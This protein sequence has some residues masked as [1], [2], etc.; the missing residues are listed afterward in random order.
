MYHW[1]VPCSVILLGPP[2]PHLVAQKDALKP[3]KGLITAYLRKYILFVSSSY[4]ESKVQS[5]EY[6]Q[7]KIKNY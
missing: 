1:H 3:T 5:I 4:S 2:Q 6:N 7:Y